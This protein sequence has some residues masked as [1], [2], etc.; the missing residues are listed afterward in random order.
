M[1]HC[2]GTIQFIGRKHR[3]GTGCVQ[4]LTRQDHIHI[5]EEGFSYVDLNTGTQSKSGH[6]YST[7]GTFLARCLFFLVCSTASAESATRVTACRK[8]GACTQPPGRYMR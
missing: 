4:I 6:T 3:V 2:R 8:L 7:V 5:K 1:V